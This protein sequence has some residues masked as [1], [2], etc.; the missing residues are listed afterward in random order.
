MNICKRVRAQ[1]SEMLSIHEYKKT[2]RHELL[3]IIFH[4]PVVT[5]PQFLARMPG[6]DI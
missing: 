1:E 2:P 5:V 6:T 3:L 4:T